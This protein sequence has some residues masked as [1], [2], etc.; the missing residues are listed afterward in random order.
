[1]RQVKVRGFRVELGE[2][3]AALAR[4]PA[5][6]D[7]AVVAG[8]A[9]AGGGTR[10]V[11][12]LVAGDGAAAATSSPVAAAGPAAL[13]APRLRA[14][15]AE[16]LPAYM[17]PAAFVTLPRLP[18]TANGKL[19]RAALPAPESIAGAGT[20]PLDA[21]RSALEQE[22]AGIWAELLGRETVGVEQD[23]FELGGHSLLATRLVNQVRTALGV[24]L[25][26]QSVFARPTVAALAL[27]VEE[28][29]REPGVEPGAEPRALG[30]P[31]SPL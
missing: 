7:V 11:A 27:T 23:F 4:H 30:V 15:L 28:L 20:A 13:A 25:P 6:A 16:R 24:E 14:Y 2:V 29:R 22:L 18:L 12:Y 26:L 8:E 9:P 17:L 10:L 31:P 3:E 21:P 5:V 19:D 1:D